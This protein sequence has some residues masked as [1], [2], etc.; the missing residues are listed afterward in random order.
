VPG[1]LQLSVGLLFAHQQIPL[2]VPQAQNK[3]AETTPTFF[4]RY[5]FYADSELYDLLRSRPKLKKELAGI[6]LH[7]SW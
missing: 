3:C 6:T 4:A 7:G 5:Q 2:G 1:D